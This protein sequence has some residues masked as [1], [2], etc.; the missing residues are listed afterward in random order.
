MHKLIHNDVDFSW[1]EPKHKLKQAFCS[2]PILAYLDHEGE[3]I[4]DTD[5][6]NYAIGD[7]LS[8]VHD[9]KERVIMYGSK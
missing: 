4:V 7:V 6:S 3:F 2:A 1:G 8:K 5:A 9:G